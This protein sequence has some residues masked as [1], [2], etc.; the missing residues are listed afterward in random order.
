MRTDAW[1][2]VV[3]MQNVFAQGSPWASPDYATASA[4]IR[5]LLPAFGHRVV[6]TRYVA[7]AEPRGAWVPYFEQWPFA[8]VPPTDALYAFTPEIE[9]LA[10]GRPVVTRET[11]GK[12]GLE[13]KAALNGADEIV[14][15]GV[16]TDCCVI[17]TALPA[18]DDGVHVIVPTDACAGA[19][20]ADHQRALDAMALYAPLIE[21]TDV[22]ALLG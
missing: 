7:P 12:W 15:T 18:A 13:L 6:F 16:S 5:R 17:S 14:L 20:A 9:G 10:V 1:L 8:L 19:S 2:V 4:G 21:L 22:D 11:F 3:D